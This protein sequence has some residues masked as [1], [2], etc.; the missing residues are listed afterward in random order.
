MANIAGSNTTA[1][2][3][4][5]KRKGTDMEKLMKRQL[6]IVD[7]MDQVIDELGLQYGLLVEVNAELSRKLSA[8]SPLVA[9]PW[10]KEALRNRLAMELAEHS[11]GG[12]N[13]TILG[14]VKYRET[15]LSVFRKLQ[16]G[17]PGVVGGLK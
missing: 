7:K 1:A 8:P 14:P 15:L 13:E 5:E 6:D 4:A 10:V 16:K 9:E 3:A 2:I 11:S 12:G 17:L